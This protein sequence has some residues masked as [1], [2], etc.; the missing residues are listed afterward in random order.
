V[1]ED[2]SGGGIGIPGV[3][4]LGKGRAATPWLEVVVGQPAVSPDGRWVAYVERLSGQVDVYVQSM[5]IGRG[6]WRISTAGGA[7]PIWRRDG[8]ELFYRS[9]DDSVMA[10]PIAGDGRLNPGVPK[11]L[12]K[13]SGFG[14]IGVRSQ[15]AVSPDGERFL[16]NKVLPD[17][18]RTILLQNWLPQPTSGR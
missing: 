17:R 18:G 12:F 14:V 13:F 9:P 11:P 10:V 3:V 1:R 7:Q 5:P 16:L 8:R 6:K 2:G 4:T 15:F